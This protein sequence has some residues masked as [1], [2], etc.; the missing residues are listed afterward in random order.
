MALLPHDD[1]GD[2][3]LVE[4][5]ALTGRTRTVMSPLELDGYLTGMWPRLTSRPHHPWDRG[6]AYGAGPQIS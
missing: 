1:G 6:T 3:E 4:L 2:G 5:P